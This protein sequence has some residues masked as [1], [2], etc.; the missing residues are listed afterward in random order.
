MRVEIDSLRIKVES[1][2]GVIS[3]LTSSVRRLV[4]SDASIGQDERDRLV[5]AA[6]AV[7]SES[8]SNATSLLESLS[9]ESVMHAPFDDQD[10]SYLDE[11]FPED[12]NCGANESNNRGL[13]SAEM[14]PTESVSS[15]NSEALKNDG[16]HLPLA[17][18]A[19]YAFI[20]SQVSA[21]GNLLLSGQR[22]AAWGN[23]Q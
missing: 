20:A 10:Y 14:V 9:F 8:G 12:D 15:S 5:G 18:A 13:V 6:R 21:P 1:M 3:Q 17:S 23:T 7:D 22:A 11:L 19:L 4:A 16:L 2:R